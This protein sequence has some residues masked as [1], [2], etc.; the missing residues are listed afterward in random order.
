MQFDANNRVLQTSKNDRCSMT[1]EA[2]NDKGIKTGLWESNR[3]RYRTSRLSYLGFH[4]KDL[5]INTRC[6]GFESNCNVMLL[7]GLE[8]SESLDNAIWAARI[9]NA[10]T[11]LDNVIFAKVKGSIWLRSRG[12]I[13]QAWFVKI[14]ATIIVPTK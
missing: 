11:E 6:D 3:S 12:M 14:Y 4:V 1:I 13:R 8:C 5:I 2:T 7:P 10:R 9:Q